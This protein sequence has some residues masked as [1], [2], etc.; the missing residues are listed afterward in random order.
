MSETS[1][2][3]Q[4]L[5]D[6]GVIH[7][8]RPDEAHTICGLLEI[9]EASG[10]YRNDNSVPPPRSADAL[11]SDRLP[12]HKRYYTQGEAGL[13]L[14]VPRCGRC[15]DEVI[16]EREELKFAKK[17]QIKQVGAGQVGSPMA[18]VVPLFGKRRSA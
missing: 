15:D 4:A 10:W 6:S 8:Y 3:N 11:W 12:K 14:R 17:V 9:V 18:S 13:E 5:A 2:F 16:K 7:A 1:L